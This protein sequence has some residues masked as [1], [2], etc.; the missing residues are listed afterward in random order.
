MKKL[1]RKDFFVQII[2]KQQLKLQVVGNR[3]LNGPS[4]I[5][6]SE[7]E[8]IVDHYYWNKNSIFYSVKWKKYEHT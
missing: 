4:L 8:V 5:L 6:P 1:E 3:K 2:Y 7:V